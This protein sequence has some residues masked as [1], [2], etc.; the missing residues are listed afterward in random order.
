M[1]INFI[2]KRKNDKMMDEK[3][4]S[5]IVEK[6]EIASKEFNFNFIAPY[7]IGENHK[8][9]FFGYLF[10]DKPERGVII[11]VIFNYEDRNIEKRKYCEDNNLFYSYLY[12]EPL[13][14]EYKRS[15]FSEMLKDWKYEFEGEGNE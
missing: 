5:S 4:I 15:Y 10:K 9:C 8:L 6:F 13:L 7:C 11:D 12:I 3:I 2:E 1:N 14:G